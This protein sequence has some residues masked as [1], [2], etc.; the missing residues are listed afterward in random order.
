MTR[1]PRWVAAL[2]VAR[3]EAMLAARLY[4]DAGETRAFEGFVV[5]MH[6]AW[7]YLLHARFIRDKIEYRY[8][9]SS[10]RRRFA[11]VDGEYKRW[12]LAKC[13][14]QRWPQVGDATRQNLEFFIG[15]RNRIEH[16]HDRHNASLS[17]AVSGH[18]QAFLLNFEE[19]LTSTF[20]EK[21]SLATS[22]RFPVFVGSFTTA[23]TEA[24]RK[25]QQQ[26]PANLEHYISDFH[27]GLEDDVLSDTR[28]EV[29]LR[30]ALE[31]ARPGED[32]L[33]MDFTR[34][35][36]MTPE[37]RDS[38]TELGRSGLV[39]VRE[40]M[41]AVVGYR[42]LMS[43][44]A[45]ERVAAA[46]PYKFTSAHFLNAWQRK[47]IRPRGK[48]DHPERTDDKYCL[49]IE[50]SK[51]YGYT[52]A[53]VQWLIGHCATAETFEEVTGRKPVPKDA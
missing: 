31:R 20:G 19:E 14:K 53:W 45:Q 16:H 2:Q 10:N 12:E 39:I 22:L 33:A 38:A 40:Q 36:D 18:A 5:H 52:E 9:D 34:V 3:S 25:L 27:A 49:Y 44:K 15:L 29:R 24:L 48:S 35:D 46:L 42:L 23:G 47:Q 1:P 51:S 28:F 4:N 26:L 37:Q 32:A 13:V 7:L 6:V 43:K 41:R 8:R 11:R 30:V 50:P 21:Y 17:L